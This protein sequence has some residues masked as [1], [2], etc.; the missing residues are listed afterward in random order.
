MFLHFLSASLLKFSQSR[1]KMI[2]YVRKYFTALILFHLNL[3]KIIIPDD[4]V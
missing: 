2:F 4:R 3:L 1:L